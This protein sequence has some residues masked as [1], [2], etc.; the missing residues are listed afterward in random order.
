MHLDHDHCMEVIAAK[1]PA[2]QIKAMAERL[3]GTKGVQSGD[4][5]AARLPKS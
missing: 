4:V 3:I 2:R 5:V 1:G